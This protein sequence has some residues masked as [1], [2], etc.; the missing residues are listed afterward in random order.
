MPCNGASSIESC[1]LELWVLG[2]IPK[3][4][5]FFNPHGG[6]NVSSILLVLCVCDCGPVS[7]LSIPLLSFGSLVRRD[8]ERVRTEIEVSVALGCC[9][10]CAK[11]S[12]VVSDR[13]WRG[14]RLRMDSMVTA[15]ERRAAP[16]MAGRPWCTTTRKAFDSEPERATKRE[17]WSPDIE[18]EGREYKRSK[19]TDCL[20]VSCPCE[21]VIPKSPRGRLSEE[22]DMTLIDKRTQCADP[23]PTTRP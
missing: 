11:W 7:L 20:L 3:G 6:R 21:F 5:R 22:K 14:V 16:R 23:V 12:G 1:E 15:V 13:V 17:G 19:D 9:T 18:D 4:E 8:T 2:G 10:S